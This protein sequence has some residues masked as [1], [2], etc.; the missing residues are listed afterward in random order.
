V[1]LRVHPSDAKPTTD[2]AAAPIT[3]PRIPGFKLPQKR[4]LEGEL[5]CYP[6]GLLGLR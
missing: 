3:A 4:G 5:V 2:M 6:A 1:P